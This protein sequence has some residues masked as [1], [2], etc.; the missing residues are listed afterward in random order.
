[1]TE[2]KTEKK[3]E[4]EKLQHQWDDDTFLEHKW[5]V[6]EQR[7]EPYLVE[8]EIEIEDFLS[9]DA[10]AKAVN[11]LTSGVEKEQVE[12]ENEVLATINEDIDDMIDRNKQKRADDAIYSEAAGLTT[13]DGKKKQKIEIDFMVTDTIPEE[14]EEFVG[15]VYVSDDD[16]R[17]LLA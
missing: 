1:M 7:A 12:A 3:T 2:K 17:K 6:F 15:P 10:E 16:I 14:E 4:P 5:H 8:K 9:G 13:E 11:I